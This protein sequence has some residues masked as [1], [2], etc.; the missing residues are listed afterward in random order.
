M[1]TA[2]RK[3]PISAAVALLALVTMLALGTSA[4]AQSA[5]KAELITLH[6]DSTS[7]TDI[8]DVLAERTQLNIVT[9]PEVQGRVISIRLSNT[10]FDEALNLVVRAAGLGY[11]RVG[12]SILVA[13]PRKLATETGLITRVFKLRYADASEVQ[14]MLAPIT[15]DVTANEAGDRLVVRATQSALEEAARV[16]TQLDERPQQVLLE[17]RLIE[18][19]TRG[20]Q[21]IGIDWEKITMWSGVITEGDFGVSGAGELPEDIPFLPIDEGSDFYRQAATFRVALDALLMDGHARLLSN[22]KVVT[23]DGQPAEIFAGETVPVVI[24]SLQSPSAGGVFQTVQLEKIDVGVR[25]A[26]TPRLCGEGYVTTLVEIEVSQI[27][28]FIGP[29]EDL[30]WT[31]TRRACS[32]VRV[33]DGEKIYLGGLLSEEERRTV[34]KVPILGQIPL[35]G[36]LFQHHSSEKREL[37]LVI[38]IT[39]RIVTEAS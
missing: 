26:I 24:T 17:A 34:K 13:D 33:R 22:A 39:P 9:S 11:E 3:S 14:Q 15:T 19:N 6:A 7:V 35:I 4:Q 2:N 31:S 8:L 23:I 21:E 1:V 20:A 16:V 30:P 10:P 28:Q 12:Q 37:D 25:L 5:A 38:E 32:L 36:Y 27:L 18:V 29:D